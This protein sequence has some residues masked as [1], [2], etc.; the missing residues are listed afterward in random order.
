MSRFEAH[1]RELD[2]LTAIEPEALD[3]LLR[4]RWT[5]DGASIVV[6]LFDPTEGG[7]T[8]GFHEALSAYQL[9]Y[10]N[11]H[12]NYGHQAFL[13]D[14]AVYSDDYQIVAMHSCKSYSYYAHQVATGKATEADPTGW[15]DADMVATGRSSYPSDSP[16]VLVAL[17]DGLMTGIGAVVAGEPDRAPSWQAIGE[18]MRSVAPSILYGVAGAR[19]N[20]WTPGAPE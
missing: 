4:Y 2:E 20:V 6:D 12:S 14:P 19:N 17:L 18:E 1:R 13:D 10:Y 11:G 16:Y 3:G 15:V 7:F 8:S 5:R 9:V